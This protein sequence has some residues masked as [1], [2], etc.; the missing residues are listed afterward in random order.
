MHVK[1]KTKNAS[2]M[3]AAKAV[4]AYSS[5]RFALYTEANFH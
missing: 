2:A 4:P 3:K 5:L 1:T